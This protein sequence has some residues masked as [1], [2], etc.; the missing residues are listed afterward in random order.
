MRTT[1]PTLSERLDAIVAQ[2]CT[3]HTTL[4]IATGIS[5]RESC[6]RCGGTGIYSQY[7]GVCFKC[8]GRNSRWWS[9]PKRITRAI[10]ETVERRLPGIRWALTSDLNRAD[11]AVVANDV[12]I[13]EE[14]G[15]PITRSAWV[16]AEGRRV[17]WLLVEQ[18]EY[19]RRVREARERDEA[20]KAAFKARDDAAGFGDVPETDDRL[21]LVGEILTTRD[22]PGYAFGS[23]VTKALIAAENDGRKFKLWG[24]LPAAISGAQRGDRVSFSAKIKRSDKDSGFGFW[25]RPTKAKNLSEKAVDSPA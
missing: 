5:H 7:H 1:K 21:D 14:R 6:T 13:W 23:Y 3:C 10:L 19:A 2:E 18:S 12:R 15:G 22:E 4:L 17:G 9:A 20:K 25:S 11:L 8:N 16:K 24:T